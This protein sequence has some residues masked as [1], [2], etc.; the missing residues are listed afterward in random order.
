MN[1]EYIV[2]G[3][4]GSTYGIK[5]EVKIFSYTEESTN[6]LSYDPWYIE[7]DNHWKPIQIEKSRDHGK[8]IVVKFPGFK[9]PEQARFL[10]GKHIAVKRSQLPVLKKGEYYWRDLEGLTVFDQNGTKLGIV[11]YLIATGSNDV[12]ILKN[13]QGKEYAVPYLFGKVI[14]RVDLDKKEIHVD[15]ELI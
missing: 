8:V 14:K 6:I 15:W 13:D 1:D 11:S 12:L 7:E 2:V 10:T 3:K 4:I 5:G 9:T